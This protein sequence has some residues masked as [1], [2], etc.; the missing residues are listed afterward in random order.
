MWSDFDLEMGMELVQSA[1][2]VP[3][4]GQVFVEHQFQ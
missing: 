4:D 3:Q 1:C 2:P